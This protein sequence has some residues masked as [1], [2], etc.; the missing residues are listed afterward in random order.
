MLRHM[1]IKLT[2]IK[3]KNKVLKTITE[4][5]LLWLSGLRTQHNVPE[6]VGSI[7]GLAQCVKDLA[8]PQAEAQVMAAAQI[9]HCCG[10]D[11]VASCSSDYTLTWGTSICHSCGLKREKKKKKKKKNTPKKEKQK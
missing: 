6:D 8:L 5:F 9:W 1:V 7:P 2:K 10:C 11:V 4:E 3:H